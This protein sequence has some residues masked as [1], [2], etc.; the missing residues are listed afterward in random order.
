[1]FW[2]I[3]NDL[4]TRL[5]VQIRL[6]GNFGFSE[7]VPCTIRADESLC[8]VGKEAKDDLY[9]FLCDFSYFRKN[10]DSLWSN[11]DVK[12][13]NSSPT[14]GSQISAFIKN[15]DQDSKALLLPVCLS[16]PFDSMTFASSHRQLAK[17]TSCALKD[18]VSLR[19]RDFVNS[20]FLKFYC[21]LS[22]S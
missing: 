8:F 9:H 7:C 16:L 10:F 4:V 15:L 17:S 20:L 11:L 1:M 3:S 14:D 18:Y 5:H 12:A 21:I 22:C 19:L 2:S 6:M 13:S